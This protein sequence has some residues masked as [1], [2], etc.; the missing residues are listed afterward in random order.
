MALHIA[1]VFTIFSI[2][3]IGGSLV[4]TLVPTHLNGGGALWC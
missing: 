1:V 3:V 4:A 2:L